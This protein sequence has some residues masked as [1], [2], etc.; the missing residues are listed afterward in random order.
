MSEFFNRKKTYQTYTIFIFHFLIFQYWLNVSSQ[1]RLNPHQSQELRLD[2]LKAR[3]DPWYSILTGSTLNC[4][5]TSARFEFRV[6][7]E[8]TKLFCEDTTTVTVVCSHSNNLTKAIV[9]GQTLQMLIYCAF[10]ASIT[11]NS[12]LLFLF[13]AII[14]DFLFSTLP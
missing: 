3:L 4:N 2:S 9:V 1:S 12:W 6:L 5:S 14:L 7:K 10:Q 13:T 11:L 8:P